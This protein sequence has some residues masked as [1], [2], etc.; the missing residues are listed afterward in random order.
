VNR[1]DRALTAIVAV[2]FCAAAVRAEPSEYALDPAQSVFAVLTH[3]TGIGSAVAHDHLVVAPKP[4]VSLRFD[5]AAP[6][7][8]A[9]SF[10]TLVAALEVD[11]PAQRAAW[12]SRFKALGIH[13]GELPPVADAD[14]AAI[15]EAMLGESQLDVAA[16]PEIHAEIVSV[17]LPRVRLRLT[18]R[19]K[20]IERALSADFSE[21][22]GM[23][24][25]ELAGAFRFTEF[26]IEP[27]SALFGAIRNDDVFHVFVSVVA[28]RMP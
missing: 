6:E 5:P 3:K 17:K 4:T 26:G 16:H 8:T 28:R 14:R 7:A 15:R 20:S 23:L 18:I 10:R 11:A 21:Q 25:A 24:K 12:Q 1:P 2:F 9:F 22:D 13:S 27:Y 19:G